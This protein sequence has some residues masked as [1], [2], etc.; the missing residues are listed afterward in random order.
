MLRIRITDLWFFFTA[1]TLSR[2]ITN[3]RILARTAAVYFHQNGVV[4]V[5]LKR[6]INGEQ[7]EPISVRGQLDAICEATL[8]IIDKILG[9]N[10]IAASDHP[11]TNEF[12]IRVHRYP[13]P[14]I[15]SLRTTLP[16]C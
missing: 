15:S 8:K 10:P 2:R 6:G 11:G 12:G 4:H 14:N 1:D 13:R 9:G 5:S 16:N 3:L 7:V